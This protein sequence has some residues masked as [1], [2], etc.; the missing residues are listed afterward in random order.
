V[1]SAFHK[2]LSDPDFENVLPGLIAEPDRA[3][4]IMQRLKVMSAWDS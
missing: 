2:L 4:L 1:A 3:D